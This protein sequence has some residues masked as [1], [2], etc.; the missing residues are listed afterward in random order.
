VLVLRRAALF[1]PT[2][3]TYFAP[4]AQLFND[5][6]LVDGLKNSISTNKHLAT[7]MAK[8]AIPPIVII[9]RMKYGIVLGNE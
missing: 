9:G 2:I 3:E 8:V 5:F 1:P 6:G 7:S 4:F